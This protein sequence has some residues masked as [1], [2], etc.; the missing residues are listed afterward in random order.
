[1]SVGLIV[2]N[3]SQIGQVVSAHGRSQS[4]SFKMAAMT[5]FNY[6]NELKAI[7][8]QLDVCW[9]ICAKFQQNRPSSFA[10]NPLKNFLAAILNFFQ[11][12]AAILD[13]S[14]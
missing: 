5:S 13:R 11:L 4:Q 12:Q 2:S 14:Y 10:T 3:F 8:K 1:M 7:H 6:A 9:T